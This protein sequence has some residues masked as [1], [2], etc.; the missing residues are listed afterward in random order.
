MQESKENII[1]SL[2]YNSFSKNY[3]VDNKYMQDIYIVEFLFLIKAL[4]ENSTYIQEFARDYRAYAIMHNKDQ[5]LDKDK[6]YVLKQNDEIILKKGIDVV[7]RLSVYEFYDYLCSY[8]FILKNQYKQ[9]TINKNY[10]KDIEENLNLFYKLYIK[11]ENETLLHKLMFFADESLIYNVRDFINKHIPFIQK[12][13]V[14][15]K[16]LTF[17]DRD[18]SSIKQ[19]LDSK[20]TLNS[21]ILRGCTN[22]SDLELLKEFKNL[23]VLQLCALNLEDISFLENMQSLTELNIANNKI[24]DIKVLAS[25]K[26]V[27]HLYMVLNEIED[28]S[29]INDMIALKSLYLDTKQIDYKNGANIIRDDINLYVLDIEC[30][31]PYEFSPTLVFERKGYNDKLKRQNEQ[32]RAI[33]ISLNKDKASHSINIK[34]RWLYSGILNSLKYMPSVLYDL[35]KLKI[36]D[37]NDNIDLCDDFLFLTEYGDY[38]ALSAATNLKKLNI[39]NRKVNDFSFL[40]K[41][42]KLESLK[43]TNVDNLTNLLNLINLQNLKNLSLNT[44]RFNDLDGID[45]LLNLK[46][47]DISNTTINDTTNIIKLGKLTKLKELTLS[48]SNIDNLDFL[49]YM[50]NLTYLDLSHCRNLKSSDFANLQ[51]LTK[52]ENFKALDTSFNNA[53]YLT[54]SPKLQHISIDD[55]LDLN[56]KNFLSIFINLKSFTSNLDLSYIFKSLINFALDKLKLSGFD[57]EVYDDYVE[58]EHT[59]SIFAKNNINIQNISCLYNLYKNVKSLCH[60][61]KKIFFIN[62]EAIL[63]NKNLI[64]PSINALNSYAKRVE[65]KELLLKN[66]IYKDK[67][68]SFFYKYLNVN[69]LDLLDPENEKD[70]DD[71]LSYQDELFIDYIDDE[72]EYF[73]NNI[74]IFAYI[75][76]NNKYHYICIKFN[77]YYSCV[78]LNEN[79]SLKI[80]NEKPIDLNINLIKF[81]YSIDEKLKSIFKY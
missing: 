71:F 45:K 67:D 73:C 69:Y 36:L 1:D 75:D 79:L 72:E 28:L 44:I 78:N 6:F 18:L 80:P 9:Y 14:N 47:L 38:S 27:N 74:P 48:N 35:S 31:S 25:L 56:D 81:L 70:Y 11:K 62:E 59:P 8:Y 19:L 76:T 53:S 41:T 15:Q 13:Y 58:Q 7:L 43:L 5:I 50:P 4:N 65:E 63:N 77:H 26:K 23:K 2:F 22:I 10:L 3:G 33:N 21:L 37:I 55:C 39:E 66:T 61:D 54:K 57:F 52:L 17:Y 64:M 32:S 49:S 29:Y 51:Y 42:T 20:D 46:F 60:K 40:L 30:I 34:D 68:E 16:S 24:K 12:T